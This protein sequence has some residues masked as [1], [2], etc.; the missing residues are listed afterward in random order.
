MI[1]VT[2]ILRS[3]GLGNLNL[4]LAIPTT[5]LILL[6]LHIYRSNSRPRTTRLRGPASKSFV[7]GVGDEIF[8]SNDVG[9]LYRNWEKAYGA[10]YEIPHSLGSKM[11]VLEDPKGIAHVLAKD[12]TTYDQRQ[13]VKFFLRA[14]VGGSRQ[15]AFGKLNALFTSL[16][17]Y[18]SLWKGRHIRGAPVCLLTSS[19]S[20]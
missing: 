1:D 7:F 11:L 19:Q 6:V 4:K 18:C 10:V 20:C 2:N 16:A 12:T 13:G 5:A 9:E 14:M 17:M 15:L 3:P 8:S